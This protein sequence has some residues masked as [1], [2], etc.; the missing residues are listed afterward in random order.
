VS[1]VSPFSHSDVFHRSREVTEESF[2]LADGRL[3]NFRISL[4]GE[5][6]CFL[7][8][9]AANDKEDRESAVREDHLQSAERCDGMAENRLVAKSSI[10]MGPLLLQVSRLVVCLVCGLDGECTNLDVLQRG[11]VIAGFGFSW[12]VQ[13]LVEDWD[14]PKGFEFGHSLFQQRLH[15]PDMVDVAGEA[16]GDAE[17]H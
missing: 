2:E 15:G 8:K 14:L 1:H 12:A 3:A 16:E 5:L 4:G 6:G 17:C 7:D 10:R 9:V 13:H 11:G